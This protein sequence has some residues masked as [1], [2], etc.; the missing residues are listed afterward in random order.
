MLKQSLLT[1]PRPRYQ[2]LNMYPLNFAQEANKLAQ[3]IKQY[4][5]NDDSLF[6]N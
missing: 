5:I 2:V 4:D 6:V 3:L 1:V